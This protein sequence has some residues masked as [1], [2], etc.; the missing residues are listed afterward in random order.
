MKLH[1]KIPMN[2]WID[3]NG[4]V[5]IIIDLQKGISGIDHIPLKCGSPVEKEN[6]NYVEKRLE[7][8][9]PNVK[10]LLKYFRENN[11]MVVF[12][13]IGHIYKDRRDAPTI[14]K[15]RFYDEHMSAKTEEFFMMPGYKQY[16]IL[17][18]IK[19]YRD[20]TII[21]KSTSG[22]F[23]GTKLDLILRN[24]NIDKLIICGGL[25]SCCVESTVRQAFDL[26]YLPTV[27]S[28]ACIAADENFH[29]NALKV[30]KTYYSNIMKTSDVLNYLRNKRNR[31]RE[32]QFRH[33]EIIVKS[34]LKF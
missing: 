31:I 23:I 7:I 2:K 32:Q 28:D 20:E 19:P 27:I 12:T 33:K 18:E 3:N 4:I 5:L 21:Q 17:D 22:A 1:F 29:N 10:K 6:E 25:T 8:V 26:G 16:E 30:L 24:N 14:Q 34:N 15:R 13:Q 11:L 9:I